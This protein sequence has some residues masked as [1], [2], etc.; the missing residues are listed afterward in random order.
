MA[1]VSTDEIKKLREATGVSVME[2]KK[3]LEEAEGD[4]EK[5]QVLLRKKSS[6]AAAKKA[7]RE[8]GAGTVAS[9]IHASKDVGAMVVL[10]CETDFVSK[11]PEFEALA[12][13]IAL[14]VTASAPEFIS[15]TQVTDEATQAAR[16][17]FEKEA[18]D[19]PEEVRTR[20]VSGKM[21]SFLAEKVLLEQP[22]VKNPEKT[23]QDLVEEATQKFGERIEISDMVRFSTR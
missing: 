21:D 15:R 8:L 9:Y 10:S 4:M 20:I 1:S 5:A 19:K 11:N 2:C 3:A 13:D 7:D 6:A 23:I 22:F 16:E 12:Y 18:A 17:V 14:H